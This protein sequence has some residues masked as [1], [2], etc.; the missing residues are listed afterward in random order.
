MKVLRIQRSAAVPGRSSPDHAERSIHRG[1]RASRCVLRLRTAA[2]RAA[3]R[4]GAKARSSVS[5]IA[6]VF[7]PIVAA[8][9]L[10]GCARDTALTS[11]PAYTPAGYA[12]EAA[13]VRGKR[14][15]VQRELYRGWSNALALRNGLA[16]VVVVPEIGRVMS[17]SFAGGE[18][19]LWED[20]SLAGR[21]VNPDAPEWINFGGDKSWPAPEAEWG[22]Y[23]G[24]KEWRPPP[25]FDAAPNDARIDG[26]E[27]VL[28]SPVDPFYGIQVQR[29]IHLVRDEPRMEITTTYQRVSGA[30][31][32]VG[33][34]II[35]QFEDPVAVFA[36]GRPNSIFT[37]GF[38]I[39]GDEP[40]PQLQR[41][42]DLIEITRDRAKPHKMG[43]D[44]DR[45][46]WIGSNAMCLVS[47]R[48]EAGREYPDRGAS[49][50]VYTNPD[51]KTY[52]EL[53]LLGPLSLLKP[54]DE[55][56]RTS[57]YQLLRRTAAD[58]Q[59]EARRVF[60]GANP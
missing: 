9:S 41:R 55:I 11:T 50:E 14:V 13:S 42:G 47:S 58:P 10:C 44:A 43:C 34:W 6:F 36:P 26:T 21:P 18:N 12:A 33:I 39:F 29:R 60:Q 38:Y 3:V 25:A 51:P 5:T 15:L 53:E 24:R 40:W 59:A 37:D 28:L 19:V 22:R 46:L 57:V 31:S 52:V 45:L 20:A 23:T 35:T 32:K 1:R 54:G 56:S 8:G 7:A 30:P 2:L 4:Y 27:V 16:E 49:A 17:F 48:R